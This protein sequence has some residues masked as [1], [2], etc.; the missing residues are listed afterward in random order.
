MLGQS[1]DIPEVAP[2]FTEALSASNE[3]SGLKEMS[4]RGSQPRSWAR[5]YAIRCDPEVSRD[6]PK[7]VPWQPHQ[8]CRKAGLNL[9]IYL[10]HIYRHAGTQPHRY[11]HGRNSD[12]G[13]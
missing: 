10:Q 6:T 11:A 4:V 9:H 5:Q 13:A 3:P 2:E 8:Q 12:T 1:A 7:V